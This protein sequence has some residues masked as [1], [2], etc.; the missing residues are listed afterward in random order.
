MVDVTSASNIIEQVLKEKRVQL[1]QL[2]K[3]KE[4]LETE[5]EELEQTKLFVTTRETA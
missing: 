4:K 1:E 3:M 2:N 5:I